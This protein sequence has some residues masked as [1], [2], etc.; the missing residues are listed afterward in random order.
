M[1]SAQQLFFQRSRFGQLFVVMIYVDEW[2]LYRPWMQMPCSLRCRSRFFK[3]SIVINKGNAERASP[4]EIS[5]YDVIHGG[6][7][8]LM[9]SCVFCRNTNPVDET[10]P[11]AHILQTEK[12]VR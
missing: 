1:K 5:R 4:C 2:V 7:L 3:G 12:Y 10:S 6:M 8:P 11:N 9:I